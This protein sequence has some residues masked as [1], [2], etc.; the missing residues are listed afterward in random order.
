M[1]CEKGAI[2]ANLAAMHDAIVAAAAHGAE[3]VAFP[4]ASITGYN[5]PARYPSAVLHVD[6]PEV[7]RFVAM[8]R[9]PAITAL[10][11]LLE[12]NPAGQPFITHVVARAGR[13]LGVYRKRTIPDDEAGLFAAG[14]EACIFEHPT[15][16]FGVAICA[17]ID[18]PAVFAESAA[19][20]ARVVFEVAAPGL[21]GPQA[22]RDWRA[23]FEWWRDECRARLGRYARENGIAIAVATQAGRTCD[24]DFPGG[25]YVFAPDG[26]CVLATPD[27]SEG[28]LYATIPLA[29]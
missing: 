11:G 9:A 29:P 4:E 28:V 26:A 16:R 8:T 5:D 3:I 22:G 18:S 19:L 6:G 1:R 17:D 15:A 14:S 24:E 23:G 20:G 25:G 10:A 27:W 21:Y 12:N 7:A 2:D 13:M